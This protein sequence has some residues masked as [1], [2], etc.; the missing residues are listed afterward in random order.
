[1]AGGRSITGERAAESGRHQTAASSVSPLAQLGCRGC[2]ETQYR[3][4]AHSPKVGTGLGG[5]E[6][7]RAMAV[8]GSA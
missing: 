4:P 2:R 1:M 3:V 6:S 5:R 7:A 8:C